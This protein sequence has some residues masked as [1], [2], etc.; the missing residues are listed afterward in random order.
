MNPSRSTWRRNTNASTNLRSTRTTNPH[1]VVVEWE[2]LFYLVYGKEI[3]HGFKDY[4][5][6]PE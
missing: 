5:E 4:E 2:R 6:R 1:I 3:Y